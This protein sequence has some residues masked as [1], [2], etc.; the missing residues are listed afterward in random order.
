[1]F[2]RPEQVADF[3]RRHKSVH[4]ARI[5]VTRQ[6]EMDE[7]QILVETKGADTDALE[8]SAANLLKVR[9]KIVAKPIGTLPDDGKVIDDQRN[10]D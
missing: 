1:M 10:Y 8:E 3:V 5:V 9:G 6:G 7:M 4:Q 2:V